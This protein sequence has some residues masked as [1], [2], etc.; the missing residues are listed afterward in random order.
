MSVIGES[1]I[2]YEALLDICGTVFDAVERVW[3]ECRD[4]LAG[5]PA[6]QD[7]D[8]RLED[9]ITRQLIVLLRLDRLL[10]G[11]PMFIDRLEVLPGSPDEPAAPLGY[12]DIAIQFH[13]GLDRLCLAIECKR[14][15][16]PRGRGCRTLAG[17]YVTHGMMRFV[18]GQY[19]SDSPVG[20]MIGYVMNGDV[21]RAYE[22]VC[23]TIV[24]KAGELLCESGRIVDHQK[25][26][27]FRSEHRR[28][29]VPIELRHLLLPM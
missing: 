4:R 15:N 12:L 6:Q 18:Q 16:L 26:F 7:S 22:A 25:P 11:R 2:W 14:L 21:E 8:A 20:G 27:S 1:R 10:R 29:P 17:P 28:V 24:E 23:R 9:P 3:P 5:R 19:A 13:A